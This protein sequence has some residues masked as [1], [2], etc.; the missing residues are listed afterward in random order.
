M[1]SVMSIYDILSMA[2]QFER[3][4]ERLYLDL[5]GSLDPADHA[6]IFFRE[7]AAEEREHAARVLAARAEC[8][9]DLVIQAVPVARLQ[10]VLDMV[11]DIHDD[12]LH[13]R[14]DPH[15]AWEILA[16]I[17]AF[18]EDRFY[19]DLED[20]TAGLPM[21]IFS[22]LKKTCSGHAQRLQQRLQ[23]GTS[24]ASGPAGVFFETQVWQAKQHG[25][26]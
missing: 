18:A 21:D 22:W 16:H 17:E 6:A 2:L 5:A 20:S 26:R 8:A 14:L 1:P 3:G 25:G 24:Q 15:A 19:G 11:E 13:S 12:V 9:P 7:I 23:K 4:L 10:S